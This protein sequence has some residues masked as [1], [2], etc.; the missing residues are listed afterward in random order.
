MLKYII[1][2]YDCSMAR[3]ARCGPCRS[4]NLTDEIGTPNPN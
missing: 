4:A 3:A 2:L 1:I